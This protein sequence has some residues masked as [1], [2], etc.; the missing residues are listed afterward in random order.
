MESKN[1]ALET[2][3]EKTNNALSTIS[4]WRPNIQM[5]APNDSMNKLKQLI[6]IHLRFIFK[7]HDE[8]TSIYT[9]TAYSKS[10]QNNKKKKATNK[11]K[12]S[13]CQNKIYL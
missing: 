6:A 4:A 5:L 3:R 2:K 11:W 12:Q 1:E 9:V 13:R 10:M 8:G 7:Q